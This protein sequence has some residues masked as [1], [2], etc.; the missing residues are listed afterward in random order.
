[1]ESVKSGSSSF[2]R[3]R[4]LTGQ[5]RLRAARRACEAALKEDPSDLRAVALRTRLGAALGHITVDA[6]R[7]ELSELVEQR[8]DDSYLKVALA[9]LTSRIDRP[10]AIAELRALAASDERDPYVQQCLAGLLGCDK[11][12]WGDAWRHY[13]A[14]MEDGPLLSPGYKA[15]AY[16]L[17]RRIQPEMSRATLRGSGLVERTSI[18]TRSL[19]IN[20]LGVALVVPLLPTFILFY[21]RQTEWG[22]AALTVATLTAAWITYSN[23]V[24]GCWRCVWFWSLMIAVIWGL[25]AWAEW[26]H[27]GDWRTWYV[28]GAV[29]V[30]IGLAIPKKQTRTQLNNKTDTEISP[31]ISKSIL[32]LI[33]LL[34]FAVV[35]ALLSHTSNSSNT[36]SVGL[37]ACP[38]APALTRSIGLHNTKIEAVAT[39]KSRITQTEILSFDNTFGSDNAGCYAMIETT[40]KA[41]GTVVMDV[42]E[43]PKGIAYS[44]SHVIESL[45]RS[46]LFVS[47]SK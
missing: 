21:A 13:K 34:A 43:I 8:P 26:S 11:E 27:S 6:A 47:V 10:S 42:R 2:D 38:N 39:F 17:S 1:M 7:S 24:V 37:S 20:R 5:C 16:S 28:A 14:A 29:S 4:R 30:I 18:Q 23:V 3:A 15:A 46:R 31:S 32:G 40:P 41:S 22:I 12:T 25:V 9:F 36:S 19:G 44:Q 33:A 45:R 35:F